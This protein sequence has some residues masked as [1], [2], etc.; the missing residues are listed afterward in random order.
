MIPPVG[1]LVTVEPHLMV[2]GKTRCGRWNGRVR[3][4]CRVSQDWVW[5]QE[6]RPVGGTWKRGMTTQARIDRLVPIEMD[7]DLFGNPTGGA[8]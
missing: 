8:R 5:V 1:E 2:D 6:I 3:S 7:L 4:H